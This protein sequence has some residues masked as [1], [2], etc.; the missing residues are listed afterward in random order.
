[1]R[2]SFFEQELKESLGDVGKDAITYQNNA[3]PC[4]IS[5]HDIGIRCMGKWKDKKEKE[6][7]KENRGDSFKKDGLVNIITATEQI[8][9][10]NSEKLMD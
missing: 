3:Q 5:G 1:M 8:Y 7:K 6:K 2:G 9:I 10:V 4:I